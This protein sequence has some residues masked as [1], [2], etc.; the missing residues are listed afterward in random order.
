MI[1]VL[2][3]ISKDVALEV[4]RMPKKGE[5]ITAESCRTGL[6]GKGANQAA[7]IAKLGDLAG[8][9][10]K[11]VKFIGKVGDDAVGVEL[12]QKLDD[13]GVDTRFLRTAHRSTGMTVATLT[14]KD[15]RVMTYGGANNTLSKTDVDEALENASSA[16]TLLCQLDSPLYVVAYALR[17]ARSLGMTTIL[18][19]A[20]AKDL[21][22]DLFYN[23]DI[24]APNA[25]EAQAITGVHLTDHDSR[26]AAM[27]WFH[28]KGVQYVVI[29]LGADG[30]VMS[31][32]AY[33]VSHV[34][35]VKVPVLDTS[36]AG[37][38]FVGALALTYPHI[39]MY[40]FREACL[41]ATRAASLSV[42]RSGAS[43]SIPTFAE[44]LEL[45]NSEVE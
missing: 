35:A 18:N 24:I 3:S 38:I 5:S 12:K 36:G 8:N 13:F 23:V 34:P 7:A 4:T 37:D 16:D 22:D 44:V 41:F 1:Y 26:K 2:G 30:A 29:S 32:G 27:R 28:A 6:G 43:E 15:T 11:I 9:G 20:P 25:A 42:T 33:I 10:R 21:P 39:G 45:Y 31:D 40:S 17:K 19:P 14:P